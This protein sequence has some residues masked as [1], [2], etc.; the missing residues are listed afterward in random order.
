MTTLTKKHLDSI[1]S[2]HRDRGAVFPVH[3]VGHDAERAT[4]FGSVGADGAFRFTWGTVNPFSLSLP[5]VLVT[6]DSAGNSLK[7]ECGS[8]A[9]TVR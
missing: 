4:F 8:T 7:H 9:G 3:F 2:A 6:L 5:V 1:A